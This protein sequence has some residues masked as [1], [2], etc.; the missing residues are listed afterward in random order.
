MLVQVSTGQ[1]V[2]KVETGVRVVH[3]PTGIT[4]SST[5]ER[6]QYRNKQKR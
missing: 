4:A 2:N 6:S 3:T 5:E 1:N